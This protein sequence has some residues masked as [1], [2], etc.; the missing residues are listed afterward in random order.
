MFPPASRDTPTRLLRVVAA[1]LEEI[2]LPSVPEDKNWGI[3][4]GVR[5]AQESFFDHMDHAPA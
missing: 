3:F 4:E 1:I 2:G 5:D